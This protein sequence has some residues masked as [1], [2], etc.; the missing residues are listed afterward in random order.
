MECHRPRR[1]QRDI[2]ALYFQPAAGGGEQDVFHGADVH[3]GLR[4]GDGD[5]L[6]GG[7]FGFG[8]LRLGG[9]GAGGGM[10]GDAGFLIGFVAVGGLALGVEAQAQCH[11]GDVVVL[12]GDIDIA[13][14]GRERFAGADDMV[15]R[16][17]CGDAGRGT[18]DQVR[19]RPG[20]DVAGAALGGLD[21]GFGVL[22]VAAGAGGGGGDRFLCVFEGVE[23]GAV[24]GFGVA[25]DGGLL[26]V[27]GF[28]EAFDQPVGLAESGFCAVGAKLFLPAFGG[29]QHALAA[30]QA[31]VG[32]RGQFG[33]VA[34]VGAAL[35]VGLVFEMTQ[36]ER[37]G[38]FGGGQLG[39]QLLGRGIEDELVVAADALPARR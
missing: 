9:H 20:G 15:F 4:A 34:A 38:V 31:A 35:V 24:C 1:G 8:T 28:G 30:A 25:F 5:G 3:V 10:Q 11:G 18:G 6:V 17:E 32:L 12:C 27:G 36:G 29:E 22:G 16:R 23:R 37:C 19:A 21:C 33:A 26:G 39:A 13:G 2:R 7:E 14:G